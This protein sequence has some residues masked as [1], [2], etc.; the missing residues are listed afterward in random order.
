[1]PADS[2][3]TAWFRNSKRA[4]KIEPGSTLRRVF[5]SGGA[6]AQA[7]TENRLEDP[8]AQSVRLQSNVI[9]LRDGFVGM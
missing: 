4:L 6:C 3:M 9:K 8:T 5:R 2:R 7:N 1:V